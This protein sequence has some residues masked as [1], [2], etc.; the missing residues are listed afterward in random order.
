M[1][2]GGKDY[3]RHAK[4]VFL[5]PEVIILNSPYDKV[6]APRNTFSR[7]TLFRRDGYRCQFCGCQPGTE[8]LTID[9]VLPRSQGGITSWENCVLACISC[10]AKKANRTPEEAKMKLLSV[11]AK[12]RYVTLKQELVR[13]DSWQA[14]LGEAYWTVNLVD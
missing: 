6:P 2:P 1:E 12:P 7:R 10:N 3:I 11:P 5:V 4:G 8:E 13:I 9:H 14:F